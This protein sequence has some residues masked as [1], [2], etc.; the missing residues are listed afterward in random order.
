MS[1]LTCTIHAL[2]TQAT[3]SNAPTMSTA[4]APDTTLTAYAVEVDETVAQVISCPHCVSSSV[5]MKPPFSATKKEGTLTVKTITIPLC[6]NDCG[7][8]WHVAFT[9]HSG[10][11]LKPLGLVI[12]I[13]KSAPSTAR[14]ALAVA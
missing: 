3:T 4:L 7:A 13:G 10:Q 14:Q 9:A 1:V 2:L 6:C 5:G 12:E 11:Q 8:E